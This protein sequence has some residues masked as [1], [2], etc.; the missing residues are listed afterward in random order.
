MK[1]ERQPPG[2]ETSDDPLEPPAQDEISE[3]APTRG[4][5]GE[6]LGEISEE[7]D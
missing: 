5:P 7:D 3:H 2:P 4:K 6:D 1:K